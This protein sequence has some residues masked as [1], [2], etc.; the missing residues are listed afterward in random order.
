V[1]VLHL[2]VTMVV[3]VVEPVAFLVLHLNHYQQLVTQ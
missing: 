1:V 2:V 3:A